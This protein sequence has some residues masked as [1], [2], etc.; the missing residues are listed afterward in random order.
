MTAKTP[1]KQPLP[2]QRAT[3]APPP[4]PG[5]DDAGRPRQDAPPATG[6][7][8]PRSYPAF[9]QAP[10]YG[11]P[12]PPYAGHLYYGSV[13]PGAPG[14]EGLFG[15]LDLRRLLRVA[16]R[17]WLTILMALAFAGVAAAFYLLTAQKVYQAR[18]LLELSVRRPRILAQQAAV[19]EEQVSASQSEEVFNTRLEKLRGA[20]VA[21]V[22]AEKLRKTLSPE[23]LEKAG[24]PSADGAWRK[25][26]AARLKLTIL[27]RTR[28]LRVEFN[29]SDPVFAAAA[30]NAFAEAAESAAFDENRTSSD[31]AVAWLEAQAVTQ[32]VDLATS[33]DALLA[34]RQENKIDVLESQRRTVDDSMIEFNKAL[35]EIQSQEA[36]ERDLLNALQQLDLKPESAGELPASIPRADEIRAALDTWMAAS[37][38][39]DSLLAKYTPRHPE[40]LAKDKMVA[41][42]REQAAEALM[43]AIR[44]TA[45]NLDLLG[46]QATS[47]QQK[48]AEQTALASMLE[49]Q[50]VGGRTRQAALERTRDAEDQAYR[51]ILGR[52]QEARLA[53]DENT[54]T[55]KIV[56][57]ASVPEQPIKPRPLPVAALAVLLGLACGAAL[58]LVTDAIEDHVV[59]PQD[60]EA[61]TGIHALAAIPHADKGNRLTLSKAT[62]DE[63]FSEVA[64]AFAGLRA[65][66]DAPQYRDYSRVVLLAS[67]VP[68]EGKTVT[69]CNLAATWARK[70]QRVLL[71]DMDLRR[72]QIAGILPMPAGHP[73]LLD[74][75]HRSEPVD[76]AALVYA[77]TCANLFVIASRPV[78]NASPAEVIGGQHVAELIAWAR[79]NYDHVVID[80]PPLGLVGDALALAAHADCTLVMARPGTSRKRVVRHTIRRFRAAGIHNLG[81]VVNDVAFNATMDGGVY[82][83]G[84]SRTDFADATRHP[85]VSGPT[86]PGKSA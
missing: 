44:T 33:E 9:P 41:L 32:R 39:R 77:S 65:M 48:K 75:L 2:S 63:R 36:R 74:A 73:G 79:A 50:I 1:P 45:A 24:A 8:D 56:E 76:F 54:A 25:L 12:T 72:P 29:H 26:F 67:S 49:M 47:L 86:G 84:V 55:A 20:A 21:A 5:L 15:S 80:A 62:L 82:D 85:G 83:Y 61:V 23:A 58:A 70:G 64:E 10:V 14:D 16:R 17:K 19:I 6:D 22:A 18:S 53:A 46:K 60:V 40:V 27:R 42:Y 43:R 57:P 13:H 71:V 34:F 52:I 28:L 59:S 68:G 11:G 30:C 3:S 35:V 7:R 37:A 51:G 81:L 78:D 69:S 31:A 4:R 66:L 38:E